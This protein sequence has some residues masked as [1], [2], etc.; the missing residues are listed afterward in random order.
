[1]LVFYEIDLEPT[2]FCFKIFSEIFLLIPVAHFA[3]TGSL[4]TE[5]F[6]GS[7]TGSCVCSYR[8]S[9]SRI[10]TLVTNTGIPCARYR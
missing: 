4:R 10:S 6:L 5:R 2:W 3:I 7:N 1:M 8:Y 9:T